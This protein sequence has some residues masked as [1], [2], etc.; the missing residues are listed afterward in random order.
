MV[1]Q[2]QKKSPEV[3]QGSL[4]GIL[5]IPCGGADFF[6]QNVSRSRMMMMMMMMMMLLVVVVVAVAVV[7][8]VVVAASF[9]SLYLKPIS[10]PLYHP[11]RIH[12]MV[13]MK[14]G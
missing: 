8:V 14:Q 11:L 12:W 10:E 7:V 6:H 3:F 2:M 9:L 4:W 13:Y 5:A 1:V